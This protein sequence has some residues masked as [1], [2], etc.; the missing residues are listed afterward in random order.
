[1]QNAFS[2]DERSEKSFQPDAIREFKGSELIL[3][4]I[5]YNRLAGIHD[6]QSQILTSSTL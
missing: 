2:I 4:I 6:K 1:M 5:T 3:P